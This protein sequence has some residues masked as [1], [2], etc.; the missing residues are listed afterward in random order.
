MCKSSFGKV[1]RAKSGST[2][3]EGV[4]AA[5]RRAASVIIGCCTL[6][7]FVD[8]SLL[9]SVH[10]VVIRTGT[11]AVCKTYSTTSTRLA[12]N[13]T[14]ILHYSQNTS[15]CISR[16]KKSTECPSGGKASTENTASTF[17]GSRS[18]FSLP[19][20]ILLLLDDLRTAD[21]YTPGKKAPALSPHHTGCL[22]AVVGLQLRL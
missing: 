13:R 2:C 11:R 14:G 1:Q 22:Q 15:F 10:T 9:Y 3:R 21:P 16:T 12:D 20:S 6:F 7:D 17:C 18:K 8:L 4:T 19:P 5:T